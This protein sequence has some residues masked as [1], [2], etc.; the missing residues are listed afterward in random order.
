MRPNQV[1]IPVIHG[2]WCKGKYEALI[3]FNPQTKRVSVKGYKKSKKGTL[4]P[5]PVVTNITYISRTLM[6]E[7]FAKTKTQEVISDEM[8]AWC[9]KVFNIA[10]AHNSWFNYNAED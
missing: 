6:Q 4:I 9:I 7:V 1:E 10:T 5:G 3:V 2:V 8:Y